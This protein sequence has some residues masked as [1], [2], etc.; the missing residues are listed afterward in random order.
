[1]KVEKIEEVFWRKSTSANKGWL[2]SND[3][4]AYFIASRECTSRNRNISDGTGRG[5]GDDMTSDACGEDNEQAHD[6]ACDIEY[7]NEQGLRKSLE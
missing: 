6:N 1:M 2:D 5:R 3:I 7:F 4:V